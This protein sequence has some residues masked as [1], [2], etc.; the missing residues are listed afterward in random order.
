MNE[1]LPL[2]GDFDDGPGQPRP[3]TC[4]IER[5]SRRGNSHLEAARRLSRGMRGLAEGSAEQ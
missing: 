4:A 3:D 2:F 5:R 1:S